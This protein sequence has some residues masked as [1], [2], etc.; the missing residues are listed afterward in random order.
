MKRVRVTVAI[1][2][3]PGL[4]TCWVGSAMAA[5]DDIAAAAVNVARYEL[6]LTADSGQEFRI[7]LQRIGFEYW[8][9]LVGPVQAGMELGY[10]E[11]ERRTAGAGIARGNYGGLGIRY[12]PR[13]GNFGLLAQASWHMQD[14]ELRLESGLEQD[15]RLYET[16][17]LLAPAL[18]VGPLSLVAGASWRRLDYREQVDTGGTLDIQ[19]GEDGKLLPFA[20]LGLI[21]E[22]DGLV[23][24][25]YFSDEQ[26]GWRLRFERNF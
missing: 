7:D 20:A 16:R 26:S 25:E 1:L 9:T 22:N 15:M 18:H 4:S 19:L 3:A 13:W 23:K 5:R 21:T 11:S 24:L 2:A 8:E 14:D 12:A 6:Q 17:A 10:S